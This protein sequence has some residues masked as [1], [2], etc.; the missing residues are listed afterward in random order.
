[1]HTILIVV[2][3][4]SIAAVVAL[5]VVIARLLREDRQRSDARVA[6]LAMMAADGALDAEPER[7]Y[8]RRDRTDATA[9]EGRITEAG[10]LAQLPDFDLRP[11]APDAAPALFAEH[12]AHSPWGRRFAVVGTLS[13]VL[14]AVL[15]AATYGGRHQA[16]RPP[17]AS[18]PAAETSNI[19]PLELLELQHA[20]EPQRLTITGVVRNPA[21]AAPLSHLIATAIVFGADGTFLTSSRAPVD[22]D[23]M[24]PG[25][26]SKF[27][28]AIPLSGEVSRY[29]IGFRSDDGTVVAHVDKRTTATFARKQEQP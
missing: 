18:A 28:I 13:A 2:T 4:L 27:A 22:V 23:T 11:A 9:S 16:V 1:M 25:Q 21:G 29:R 10:A 14:A 15:L 26:E 17:A 6:A 7:V 5:S 24:G 20:R 19:A 3:S 12:D 8:V